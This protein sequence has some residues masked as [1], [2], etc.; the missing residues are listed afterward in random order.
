MVIKC[1]EDGRLALV[2]SGKLNADNASEVGQEM[3]QDIKIS[4]PKEM[5]LD[6]SDLTYISSMGLRE[7]LKVKKM[8]PHLPTYIIEASKDI[9]DIF[10]VTGFSDYFVI[11]KKGEVFGSKSNHLFE[12]DIKSSTIKLAYFN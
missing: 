2:I 9:S 12:R 7:L 5:I 10:D 11:Y 3:I 6:F 1:I 8:F 4:N